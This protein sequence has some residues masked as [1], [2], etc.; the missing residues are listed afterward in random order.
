MTLGIIIASEIFGKS[1]PIVLLKPG[2]FC[3]ILV[4]PWARIV[5]DQVECMSQQAPPYVAP[6]LDLCS[7]NSI[8][9]EVPSNFNLTPFDRHALDGSLGKAAQ[10]A[11]RV[12]MKMAI[13]QGAT[14]LIDIT[15]AHIDGCIYTGPA[16]LR[17]A[18]QLCSWGAK[19]RVPTTLNSISIDRRRWRAQGIDASFVD[20][21]GQLADAYLEMGASPTYTCAPYLLED[22][23]P[24][25][26]EQII[27]AESNAVVFANS[28][29]GARTIKCPDF[30]DICVALTGRAPN[31]GC[32]I[33]AN[34]Q[35]QIHIVLSP[36]IES[37]VDKTADYDALF[38]ILGHVIG[39]F[40][41]N[42]ISII[43]GLEEAEIDN[44]DLKAFSAAFATTSS[45]PMFHIAGITP[46]ASKTQ[47]LVSHLS[48]HRQ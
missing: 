12:I 28:V 35:A 1:I 47:D 4:T 21:A 48:T 19:V 29:L 13:I 31:T 17:F 22:S 34:R 40:A 5:G 41:E 33:I 38:P 15:Q 2:D 45:A 14:E 23:A 6:R 37:L 42:R 46:E 20:P 8:E 43:K 27:W 44:D 3:T 26:D 11:A 24:R 30:L 9:S 39:D 16:S 18:Q 32:H 36:M 25:R 7:E 10:V